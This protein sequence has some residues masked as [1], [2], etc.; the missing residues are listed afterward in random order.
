MRSQLGA[1]T[2]QSFGAVKVMVA[3]ARATSPSLCPLSVFIPGGGDAARAPLLPPAAA[4]APKLARP[5]QPSDHAPMPTQQP[6]VFGGAPATRPDPSA[7]VPAPPAAASTGRLRR[8]DK[9]AEESTEMLGW[10]DDLLGTE[11]GQAPSGS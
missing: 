7:D 3:S 5:S 1:S 11:K 6:R 4:P 8:K 10:L 9:D 2:W